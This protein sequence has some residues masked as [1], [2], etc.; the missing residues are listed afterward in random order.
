VLGQTV[1]VFF[2][3]SSPQG[4]EEAALALSTDES[5]PLP[6]GC[7]WVRGE[8]RGEVFD[9]WSTLGLPD[10]RTVLVGR[11]RM[12]DGR[13]GWSAGLLPMLF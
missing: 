11:V 13:T 10:G 2:L 6:S 5:A 1:F 4:A 9:E 7:G 12:G 8:N 3:C